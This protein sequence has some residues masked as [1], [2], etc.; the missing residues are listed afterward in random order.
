MVYTG[1]F[2]SDDIDCHTDSEGR[3]A[4]FPNKGFA[5]FF[6]QA[7]TLRFCVSHCYSL[8]LFVFYKVFSQSLYFVHAHKTE[9]WDAETNIFVYKNLI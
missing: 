6:S 8:L 3:M 9:N 7:F 2:L 1:R 4:C 5:C